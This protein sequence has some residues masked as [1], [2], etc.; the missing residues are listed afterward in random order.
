M[1]KGKLI[2]WAGHS[3]RNERS[4]LRIELENTP[5]GESPIGKPRLRW[6]DR[7]KEDVQKV[8]PRME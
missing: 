3:W 6:E 2:K 5:R 4:L 7:V 1:I 8:S